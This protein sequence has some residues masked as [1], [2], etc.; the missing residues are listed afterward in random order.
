[1]LKSRIKAEQLLRKNKGVLFVSLYEKLSADEMA[2]IMVVVRFFERLHIY[3]ANKQVD[4]KVVADLFGENFVY[5]Q[6]HYLRAGFQGSWKVAS[7]LEALFAWFKSNTDKA[8][9]DRWIGLSD[10]H[11]MDLEANAPQ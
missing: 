1:M 4:P 6:T 11:R 10:Q 2:E 3:T 7:Q 5:Y 9:F 8:E